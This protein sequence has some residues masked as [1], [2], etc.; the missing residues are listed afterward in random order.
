M[1]IA[2]FLLSTLALLFGIVY[3]ITYRNYRGLLFGF[4]GFVLLGIIVNGI[5]VF[6]NGNLT[7]QRQIVYLCKAVVVCYF[8]IRR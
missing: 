8:A 6:V 1:D 3:G 4:A 7:T 5:D 2:I